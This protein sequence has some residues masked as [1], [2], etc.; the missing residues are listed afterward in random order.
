MSLTLDLP[1]SFREIDQVFEMVNFLDNTDELIQKFKPEVQ[2]FL[3]RKDFFK[4]P[5][6]REY[7]KQ[8]NELIRSLIRK[9]LVEHFP[10]WSPEDIIVLTDLDFIKMVASPYF[11]QKN[12]RDMN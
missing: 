9:E 6:L 10:A 12:Y 8:F 4:G 5:F 3:V 7:N 11:E 1:F 2:K